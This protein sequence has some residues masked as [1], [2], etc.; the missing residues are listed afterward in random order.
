MT[1]QTAPVRVTK[2]DGSLREPPRHMRHS[3][4]VLLCSHPDTV[5][6]HALRGARRS[7]P[8]A[9]G[10]RTGQNP[11]CH[12]AKESISVLIGLCQQKKR[13]ASARRSLI[14]IRSLILSEIILGSELILRS[15]SILTLVNGSTVILCT[16]VVLSVTIVLSTAVIL[17][18]TVV[19][20]TKSI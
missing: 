20:A 2:T 4:L 17:G 10:S 18:S 5:H 16:T 15:C 14:Q 9:L 12:T 7:A 3:R 8:P 1:I 19:H 11:H 6:R 13:Q